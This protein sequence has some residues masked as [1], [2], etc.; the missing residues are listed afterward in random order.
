M[1]LKWL[2]G[3]ARLSIRTPVSDRVNSLMNLLLAFTS[4]LWIP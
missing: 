1:L 2:D 3:I 4:C